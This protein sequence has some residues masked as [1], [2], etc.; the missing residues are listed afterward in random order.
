MRLKF[1]IEQVIPIELEEEKVT[2]ANSSI[3]TKKVIETAKN[4]GGKEHG[5]CVV[6]ALLVCLRWFKRQAI[7]E[8]WDADLHLVRAKACE[9][10]AKHMYA[11]PVNCVVRK[12]C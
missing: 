11:C 5:A 10:L 12:S 7:L 6:Y 2:R 3:V 8:L 4:A 9:M 1:Q